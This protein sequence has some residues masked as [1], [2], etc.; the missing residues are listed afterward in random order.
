MRRPPLTATAAVALLLLAVGCG[1][2][3]PGTQAAAAP[4]PARSAAAEEAAEAARAAHDR[5]FPGVG[6]GCA[7]ASARPSATSPAA[8]ASEPYD[9]ERAKYAENHAFKRELPMRPDA[10]C[11]GRAHAGRIAEALAGVRD[12]RALRAA[13]EGLGYPADHIEVYGTDTDPAFSLMVPGVGPCVSGGLRPAVHAEA[14]GPY[15]EGGCVEPRGG[16]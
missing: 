15:Q 5:R 16:H 1:T 9:P 8:T 6:A 2:E 12:G 3:R 14:H 7:R 4:S 13:L 10:E 11:R